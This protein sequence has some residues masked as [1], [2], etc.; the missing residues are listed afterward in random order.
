MTDNSLRKALDTRLGT[1]QDRMQVKDGQLGNGF[2][3]VSVPGVENYVYVRVA[4]GV[5]EVYNSRTPLD[6]GLLVIVGKDSNQPDLYQVLS[7]RSATPGGVGVTIG[8]GYAPAIRYQWH[9]VGGGQD[10]LWVEKRQY[11]PGRVGTLGTGMTI[12]ILPDIAWTGSVM[13]NVPYQ[14]ADLT[15]FIP[16]TTGKAAGVLVSV[17]GTGLIVLTKGEEV[18]F[19]DLTLSNLPVFPAGSAKILAAVRVYEGQTIL[20]D[21]RTNSDFIDLRDVWLVASSIAG[22][23]AG[24]ENRGGGSGGGGEYLKRDASNDPVTGPLD[25]NANDEHALR[26][27]SAVYTLGSEIST[28]SIPVTDANGTTIAGLTIGD[29]YA[30]EAFGGGWS[31]WGEAVIPYPFYSFWVSNNG[32]TTWYGNMG[33]NDAIIPD[34]IG[35]NRFPIPTMHVDYPSWGSFVEIVDAHYV[36]FY[37]RATTTSIKIGVPD[38]I[39]TDNGGALSWRLCAATAVFEEALNVDT[40]TGETTVQQLRFGASTLLTISGGSITP[41]QTWHTVDTE[42]G[43]STDELDTITP[44]NDGQVL[45]LRPVSGS[46]KITV[47]AGVGNIALGSEYVDFV[48]VS[49]SDLL[50]FIYDVNL[51][52]W[53]GQRFMAT[54]AKNDWMKE[55]YFG[56]AVDHI[57]SYFSEDVTLDTTN[58]TVIIDASGGAVTVTLPS[59]LGIMGRRY[60]IIKSDSSVNAVTIAASSGQTINGGATKVLSEQYAV[61]VLCCGSLEWKLTSVAGGGGTIPVKASGTEVDIGTDDAKF[62]TAKALKDS[63][64]V[65]SV[66]P[67]TA[68]KVLTSDGT[69]WISSTPTAVPAKAIGTELDTGTDDA[70][71][72]TAKAIKDAHNVPSVAPGTSGNVMKSDGT[73][74]V[75]GTVAGTGDVVGPASAIDGHLAVFDSTTGKL[76]KDGGAVPGGGGGSV[77]PS[78]NVIMN[79][80][81]F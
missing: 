36:R 21:M 28:G 54:N 13:V 52:E 64:N 49:D 65:P 2:G 35:G 37:F 16:T 6:D 81:F 18:D 68:G 58:Y 69:D 62:T 11:L 26:V 72:A 30:V 14:I 12:Q 48:T 15:S 3:I 67:S 27:Q 61:A 38:Y 7:T 24:D 34:P 47:L 9:A 77:P 31:P 44:G 23:G 51:E 71:F 33:G 10:P 50:L 75:S 66:V 55:Q 42:G 5:E 73:D 60:E 19:A 59:F 63:H 8:S 32:G 78:L 46:R 29:W 76:I 43:A 39:P 74:W 4:G 25:I 70:K 53:L 56:A 20:Y 41:T 57:V 22:A 17:G 45:F 80:N 1:K 79:T 40:L